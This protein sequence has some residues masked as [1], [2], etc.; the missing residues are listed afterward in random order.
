MEELQILLTEKH[1]GFENVRDTDHN[2]N[3]TMEWLMLQGSSTI[4]TPELLNYNSQLLVTI[5][6]WNEADSILSLFI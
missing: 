2:S 4:D 6:N 3:F 5:C 1:K